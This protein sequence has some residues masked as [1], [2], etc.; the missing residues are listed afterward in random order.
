MTGDR[1][2]LPITV[3]GA[4]TCEDTAVVTGRL[5][6]LGVPFR[7]V[8]IDRDPE[9]A[10]RVATLNGGH[11]VTP[12]V[13]AGDDERVIAEPSLEAL[14]ALLAEA[15]HHVQS[16]RAT[17]LHGDVTS[18]SVPVRHLD[19]TGGGQVSLER[20][21]GRR[22]TALF[23][24]HDAAC[25]PCFGYARQL[26]GQRTALDDAD[27]MPLLV[28]ADD[29]AAAAGWRHGIDEAVTIAADPDGAWKRSVAG[30]IGAP[31]SAAMLVL[32]DRFGAPR[33]TSVAEE[34][35]GLIDPVGAVEWLRFLELECP[36]CSGELP[37]PSSGDAS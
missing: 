14:G 33:V 10:R 29:V 18:R 37:W 24:A 32:L 6:A 4:V 15:G 23:L 7:D 22:Q 1:A 26:S 27:A 13:V 5:R 8:D 21:R 3:L 34:A 19:I 30:V 12:T 31:A 25:L 17:Q 36:E 28:V 16:P 9:A 20:F 35:G 11:R 2:P